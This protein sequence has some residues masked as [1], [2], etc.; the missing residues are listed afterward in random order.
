MNGA[1]AINRIMHGEPSAAAP[2]D[3][4]G[5][6]G[7]LMASIDWSKTPTGP[8][9]YWPVTLQCAL[10]MLLKQRTPMFL[11]WGPEQIQFYNDACLPIL[12]RKHPSAMGKP[13]VESWPESWP[14]V[15]S[16][17][18][19]VQR[20]ESVSI[21]D[22]LI[23]LDRDGYLEESH[24]KYSLSPITDD[25]GA[26]SGTLC[27][28][29]DTT[30]HII[31]ERRSGVLR[32]LGTRHRWK[33]I[34][35]AC[36]AAASTLST[37]DYDVP[38]AGLYLYEA[39]RRSAMLA[40]SA[41]CRV[42]S[43]VCPHRIRLD[44]KLNE[45]L[46]GAAKQRKFVELP[47]LAK[48]I[49]P[50]PGGPWAVGSQSAIVAPLKAPGQ[51]APMGFLVAGLNP[52]KRLDPEYRSF[53]E[54]VA[55]CIGGVIAEARGDVLE[56]KRADERALGETAAALLG[57]IVDSSDDAIVSKDLNGIITSWNQAAERLFGYS[58]EE[59]V[60]KSITI[61][62]PEER[63]DEETEI[64][65][66]IRA[67]LKVDHFETIR[68]RKDGSLVDISVTISPIRDAKGRVMGASKIA[69]N[70]TEGKRAAAAIESLNSQ[71]TSDLLAMARMQQLS[72]R[73]VQ[74]D[75]VQTLFRDLLE[76]AIEITHADMGNIQLL[77]DG[78]LQIVA[79][80]GFDER[81]LEFF[82]EVKPGEAACGLALQLGE[83]TIVDD[84]T[85]SA[86]FSD[87]AT[88]DML[89][90]AGVRAVQCTPLISRFGQ[91][92]GMLSTH[93]R[94]PGPVSDRELG[95]LDVLAREAADLIERG[96]AENALRQSEA[97]FRELAEAVPQ[98]IWV[99]RPDGEVDYANQRW[100]AYSGLDLVGSRD[101]ACLGTMTHRDDYPEL[102]KRW[103]HSLATGETL[104]MEVR[105][106]RRDGAYRWF[107]IRSAALRDDS[108]RIVKWFG[109]ASDI[110]EQKGVEAELRRVNRD[111]EQFAYS[112]SHDLQEP[113]RVVK[114]YS[115]LLSQRHADKLDGQAL[116]FLGFLRGG[117]SRME[118]LIR[119]LLAYT[120]VTK[121]ETPTENADANQ[122]LEDSLANLK[123]AIAAS[124]ARVTSDPLPSCRIHATHL[125]QL[126]Q[127]LVGNAIKYRDSSRPPE[128]RISAARQTGQWV[129][130]VEDNGIGIEP[131][132]KEHIFGLFKRLHSGDEHPGTGIG[133]AICQR[134]VERYHGRIWVESEPGHG[135]TFR[136][137]IPA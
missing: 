59:A 115:D 38:F 119:D 83:R 137:T 24:F 34:A 84:V 79:Q 135:S 93:H 86:T 8:V 28:V 102:E 120:Q 11:L 80:R 21:E 88:R 51:S 72:T 23:L 92:L 62:I 116:E 42:G 48:R 16:Q 58:S 52:F 90:Q 12:G 30:S 41:G 99:W 130:A 70:I 121:L 134:I 53:L 35:Q 122:A 40:A 127:N 29:A 85:A 106:R 25:S 18:E 114:I 39:D 96:R 15:R 91:V 36:R 108:G 68:K 100:Q 49:G 73:M 31:G 82:K 107:V 27:V 109:A 101:P 95:M 110:D 63:L 125:R 6:T 111:L 61:L 13:C 7:D 50:L 1:T 19:S 22:A 128:I 3:R 44:G 5:Q 117:A 105:L 37:A 33:S 74:A 17:V 67:G 104:E 54:R 57:A 55:E 66:R 43:A 45:V 124:G 81:F 131:D 64:L 132:Y 46:A 87:P 113:L 9:E 103:Q 94:E 98:F 56:R 76:A 32:K 78:K 2:F 60:G 10:R 136:F 118:A 65:R 129:F 69:R 97:R 75:D 126:F 133:L 20:G 47:D 26:V 4:G 123:L 71:L 112:A 14:V 89:L 77:E